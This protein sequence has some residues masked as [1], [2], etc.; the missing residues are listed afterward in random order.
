MQKVRSTKY[1][2]LS[3]EL[4]FKARKRDLDRDS[5]ILIHRRSRRATIENFQQSSSDI[6]NVLGNQLQLTL[7][8]HVSTRNKSSRESLLPSISLKSTKSS[9]EDTIQHMPFDSKFS[10]S[11]QISIITPVLREKESIHTRILRSKNQ[12]LKQYRNHRHHFQ[13]DRNHL[14]LKQNI[15]PNLYI[16]S[17]SFNNNS[18]WEESIIKTDSPSN[19][20]ESLTTPL[21]TYNP[22]IY[23]QEYDDDIESSVCPSPQQLLS[24]SDHFKLKPPKSPA[25]RRHSYTNTLSPVTEYISDE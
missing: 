20:E 9:G 13:T 8:P 22:Q 4:K 7:P 24:F 15:I 21:V 25:S 18:S 2:K 6:D 19:E 10:Q 23:I 12:S 1:N 14:A 16:S 17:T 3:S 5:P 11:R